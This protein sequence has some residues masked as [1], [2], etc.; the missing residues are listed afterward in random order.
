MEEK[1]KARQLRELLVL[2][3]KLRE[4]AAQTRDIAYIDLFLRAAAALEDRAHRL[5][6]GTPETRTGLDTKAVSRVPVDFMC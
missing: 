5:A 3:K 6:Y 4:S 2:A 1:S